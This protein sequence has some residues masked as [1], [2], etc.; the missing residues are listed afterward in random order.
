MKHFGLPEIFVGG[1]ERDLREELRDIALCVAFRIWSDFARPAEAAAGAHDMFATPRALRIPAEME[2]NRKHLD[3]ARGVPNRGGTASVAV[4]LNLDEGEHG[5]P[6]LAV[7]PPASWDMGWERFIGSVCHALFGFEKPPW[8]YLP[9]LGVLLQALES[10][11]EARRRFRDAE[12]PSGGRMLV[13]YE[14]PADAGAPLRWG[15]VE[16]WDDEGAVAVRDIG[17]EL[18]PAVRPGDPVPVEDERI[19]DWA[20]WVDGQGVVEGARTE[21]SGPA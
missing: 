6:V 11:P 2:I 12:L 15:R 7:A 9:E 10:V 20:V 3:G 19:M 18:S 5:Q 21:T 8:H 13:R 16:S 14:D 4:R 17:T 1:T